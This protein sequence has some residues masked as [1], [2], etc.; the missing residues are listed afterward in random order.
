V[1]ETPKVELLRLLPTRKGWFALGCREELQRC[2]SKHCW[3]S[4]TCCRRRGGHGT[5][6][7]RHSMMP[8]VT[9]GFEGS[10]RQQ[11]LHRDCRERGCQPTW[12]W[13]SFHPLFVHSVLLSISFLKGKPTRYMYPPSSNLFLSESNSLRITKKKRCKIM[14]TESSPKITL[15]HAFET[16]RNKNL[17]HLLFIL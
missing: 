2:R 5:A 13:A 8:L 9:P 17:F 6:A 1:V 7:A 16:F 14:K 4:W 11:F 10:T 12:R 15:Y 3:V